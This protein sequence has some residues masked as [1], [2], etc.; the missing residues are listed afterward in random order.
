MRDGLTTTPTEA[1][2]FARADHRRPADVRSSRSRR[3]SPDP[4]ATGLA[5]GVQV[6]DDESTI[7]SMSCSRA[8]IRVGLAPVGQDAAWSWGAA[9][10]RDRR[11]ISGN[12][13][14]ASTASRR[15]GRRDRRRRPAGGDEFD[16]EGEAR[17]RGRP[18]HPCRTHRDQRPRT[19]VRRSSRTACTTRTIGPRHYRPIAEAGPPRAGADSPHRGCAPRA[20]RDPV[21]ADLDRLLEHDGSV[22]DPLVDQEHGH[23]GTFPSPREGGGDRARAREGRQQAGCH[24]QDPI[25]ERLDSSGP[26]I[27][28]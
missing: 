28:M 7:G 27:R 2:F 15:C 25:G 13:V 21:G 11:A 12:P 23:H 1:K 4:L 16:A 14:N 8:V 5:E 22:I 26:T 20:H 10:S 18:P 24:V 17:A 6:H 19:E 3:P 9:S